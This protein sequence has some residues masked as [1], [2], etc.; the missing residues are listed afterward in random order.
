MKDTV[1]NIQI[2]SMVIADFM[3]LTRVGTFQFEWFHEELGLHKLFNH[4]S[5]HSEYLHFYSSWDWLIPT[6]QKILSMEDEVEKLWHKED[7]L[8]SAYW[9]VENEMIMLRKDMLFE[10]IFKFVRAYNLTTGKAKIIP[11][12][13]EEYFTYKNEEIK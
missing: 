13:A 6:V 12:I 3:E 9:G 1:Q 2:K 7:D 5:S 10:K 8:Y 11:E 4:H